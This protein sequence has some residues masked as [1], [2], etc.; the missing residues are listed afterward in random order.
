[1][2]KHNLLVFAGIRKTNN[3]YIAVTNSFNLKVESKNIVRFNWSC[4]ALEDI[5]HI[6]S[7][8]P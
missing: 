8:L 1:M 5:L 4:V 6:I 3:S 2:I 7:C